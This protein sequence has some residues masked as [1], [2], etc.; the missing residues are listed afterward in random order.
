MI[1]FSYIDQPDWKMVQWSIVTISD[2]APDMFISFI[3]DFIHKSKTLMSKTTN[4]GNCK[5]EVQ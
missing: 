3:T 5:L 1:K 2:I 4:L